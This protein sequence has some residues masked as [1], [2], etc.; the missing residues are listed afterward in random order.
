MDDLGLQDE[1]VELEN[2]EKLHDLDY[3]DDIVW[4]FEPTEDV[5]RVLEKLV[6]AV[7]PFFKV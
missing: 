6:M 1:G 4:L 2:E 3:V 5:V 7:A